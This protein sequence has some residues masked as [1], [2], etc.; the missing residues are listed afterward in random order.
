MRYGMIKTLNGAR[1]LDA[2]LSCSTGLASE[3]FVEAVLDA[4]VV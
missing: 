2:S 1:D 3:S 4:T